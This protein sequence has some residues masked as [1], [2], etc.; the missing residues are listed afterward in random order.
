[1]ERCAGCAR[2]GVRMT[3]AATSPTV[4]IQERVRDAIA[5]GTS[6]RVVGKGTWLEAGMP[7]GPNETLSLADDRGIVE[8]VPGDLTLTARA[9]TTITDLC[10]AVKKHE[11]WLPLDPWGGD[12]GTIG[13]TIA[14]ATAGPHAHAMGLPRDVVLGLECVTG[15]G[16]AIRAGGRVVKN[17]AGFDLARL[18]T[19][20]WGTLGVITEITVRLRAR[21]AELRTL[22]MPVDPETSALS[23]LA[24]RLR[25]LPFTPLAAEVVN[26]ALARQLK[27]GS[28]TALIVR[29]GGNS[30]SVRAAIDLLRSVARFDDADQAIWPRLREMDRSV[31][32][33]ASWRVSARPASFGATW[34]SA[35]AATRDIGDAFVHGSIMRGVVRVIAS[36]PDDAIA[37][38]VN[39]SEGTRAIEML[40]VGAWPLVKRAP[41]NPLAG[42]LRAT[43]DPHHVLN[44]GVFEG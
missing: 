19:G 37:K 42:R 25:T 29:L 9:G 34:T 28:A 16:D 18:M 13:A 23:A 43:F 8:Y 12:A 10:G 27:V 26:P 39:L 36:G 14:T 40:G 21:P 24:V 30:A 20:A 22:V 17:V 1:M 38:A 32:A 2:R 11:Q 6:L 35:T 33:T 15:N 5:R 4:A 31:K 3:V 7:A 44:P 41:V